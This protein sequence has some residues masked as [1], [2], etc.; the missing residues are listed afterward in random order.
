M[1]TTSQNSYSADVH[2][3]VSSDFMSMVHLV[4][5]ANGMTASNF[6]RSAI[7]DAIRRSGVQYATPD[8]DLA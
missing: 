2:F 6:M 1:P 7:V 8:R 3:R 4:A 5:R